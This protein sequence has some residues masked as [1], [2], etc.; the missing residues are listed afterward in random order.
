MT[1]RVLAVAVAVAAA[2]GTAALVVAGLGAGSRAEV[3]PPA[4]DP[5]LI[6]TAVSPQQA[7]FGDRLDASLALTIDATRVD[8]ETVEVAAFFRPFR[9]VGPLETTRT[10]LGETV[11]LEYRYP[12]QCVDRGCVSGE[13]AIP[14][15][16]GVVRYAPRSGPIG[17]LPLTWPA[18]SLSSRLP[19]E[20]VELLRTSPEAIVLDGE[21]D[22]P[23]PVAYGVGPSALGW[24]LVGAGALVV[25]AAGGWLAWRLRGPARAAARPEAAAG[26]LD[27]LETAVAAVEQ[28][29]RGEDVESRRAALDALALELGRHGH[30]GPARE[31]R[32]LA[33][34]RAV[35]DEAAA[36]ALLDG[37]R[38]PGRDAA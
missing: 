17:S 16:V 3:A 6:E 38:M 27:P 15:P 9:R 12:I 33:W 32:R 31:A 8:P 20:Q 21:A 35:P 30:D 4:G 37:L 26:E 34:S 13:G 14:L 1:R 23:P 25:L 7:L 18:I 2:A 19:A 36:R 11:V 10:E 28:A 29:L 24:L 5:V 22:N